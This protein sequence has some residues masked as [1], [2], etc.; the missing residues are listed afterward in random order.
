MILVD[1]GTL[2]AS[3]VFATVLRQKIKAEL[4][5]ERTFGHAGR[6]GGA[7]LSSGGRLL[8]T[9]AFY[10]GPD[11][12]PLKEALKPDLL[13][14]ERSRTYLEKDVPIGDL[15][16][17]RGVR[18]LLGEDG[19]TGSAR[20]LEESRVTAPQPAADPKADAQRSAVPFQALQASRGSALPRGLVGGA[21][22]FYLACD[23]RRSGSR[24]GAGR[25]AEAVRKKRRVARR[26]RIPPR[27]R[28]PWPPRRPMAALPSPRPGGRGCGDGPPLSHDGVRVAVVIDDLGPT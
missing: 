10:T 26:V 17:R 6:Q 5:G 4:V 12:K 1:R 18:R 3:E 21:G 14:D 11:K 2:G 27:D 19:E 7:D 16:L 25:E 23:L 22:I 20:R 24:R 8:F 13:V 28:G 9:D 15:I